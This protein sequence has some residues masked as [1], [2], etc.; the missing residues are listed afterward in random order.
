M[1]IAMSSTSSAPTIK[2]PV[3]YYDEIKNLPN[4]RETLLVDVREPIEIQKT[5][6]IPTSI[7]V[8]LGSVQK[9]FSKEMSDEQFAKSYNHTKPQFKDEIIM[10]CQSGKRAEIAAETLVNLGYKQ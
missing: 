7:N 6:R 10:S 1:G 8:P 4:H 9:A 3:A 2:V 5:G